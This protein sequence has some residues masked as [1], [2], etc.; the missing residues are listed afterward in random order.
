MTKKSDGVPNKNS[1]NVKDNK[2]K[3]WIMGLIAN[4]TIFTS[5]V[6]AGWISPNITLLQ[7]PD[8]PAG[9]PLSDLEISLIASAICFSAVF[10]CMGY[11]FIA[12]RYGRKLCIIIIASL[13][14]LAWIIKLTSANSVCLIISQACV[15]ASGSGV[16]TICPTYTK[17]ISSDSI[18][19]AMSSVGML[20]QSIGIL[21]MY[22]LGAYL[23]YYTVLYIG[24]AIP[25]LNLLFLLKVPES[26]PHLVKIGKIE[27]A[28]NTI[29]YL[30][31][32]DAESKPVQNA[33]DE[34]TTAQQQR[35]KM[36]KMTIKT[37]FKDKATRRAFFLG[38][39][40]ISVLDCGGTFAIFA[41]A[42]VII[43]NSGVTMNPELQALSI[44]TVSILGALVSTVTIE[45][46]GRKPLLI[47]CLT[48]VGL[49]MA[50]LGT[51]L[52]LQDQGY[53]VYQWFPIIA[54][55]LGVFAYG[56]GVLPV[57]YTVMTEIFNYQVR[58]KFV[59][60]YVTMGWFQCF[61]QTI[62]FTPISQALGM[63]TMFFIFSAINLVSAVMCVVWMPETKGKSL[64]QIQKALCA[65]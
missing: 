28:K 15:G 25:L 37:A 13:Q 24:L 10:F 11:S 9:Y 19:G 46:F 45:K 42:S 1:E 21:F 29:A 20:L 7:G 47:T 57:P 23:D 51:I 18:R 5:G 35:D 41:Y 63:H 31:G 44:P 2:S 55:T 34:M 50:G 16:F 59:G 8:S 4:T 30:T 14:A 62:L 54:I 39:F 6:Q 61:L 65:K 22:A 12:D 56:A 49:P 40:M 33:I 60:F 52:M 27:E 64:H 17:E 26:P 3:Q 36:P 38:L 32:L 48:M 43:E 58:A 53:V